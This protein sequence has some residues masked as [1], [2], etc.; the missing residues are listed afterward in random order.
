MSSQSACARLP[1]DLPQKQNGTS[2][3]AYSV[4]QCATD[5]QGAAHTR[6]DV[7]SHLLRKLGWHLLP[8]FFALN[9]FNFF[10][11][12]NLSFASIQMSHDLHLTEV[13]YGIGAG[14]FFIA[15]ALF[16][17]PSQICLRHV[18][19]PRWLAAIVVA[20]GAVASAMAAAHNPATFYT[21]RLLLGVT[22]AGNFPG[23]WYYLT[24][25]FPDKHI[26]QAFSISESG[27][28]FASVCTCC[29]ILHVLL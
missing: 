20:W 28:Q 8:V 23:Y 24:S 3:P 1:A 13:Q 12:T 14:V 27:I 15:Y 25:F 17:V 6:C 22:E 26:T 10:D 16:Q 9:C 5:A 21:L 4:L 11:R 2:A 19:A 7:P 18:G 29:L